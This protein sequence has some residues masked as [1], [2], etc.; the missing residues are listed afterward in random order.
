ETLGM[1][2]ERPD[3]VSGSNYR[4]E[5]IDEVMEVMRRY[6]LEMPLEDM[7]PTLRHHDDDPM[8]QAAAL[9][10]LG[11]LCALGPYNDFR[12]AL[13]SYQ[14]AVEDPIVAERVRPAYTNNVACVLAC[15]GLF[16][17]ARK[18]L[19]L[20]EDSP[21]VRHNLALMRAC[22][23]ERQLPNA[24]QLQFVSIPHA[25]VSESRRTCGLELTPGG[26][27]VWSDQHEQAPWDVFEGP[28]GVPVHPSE[29]EW[30][31]PAR[32]RR[33]LDGVGHVMLVMYGWEDSGG[34]T[35]LPRQVAYELVRRGYQVSVFYAAAEESEEFGPYAVHHERDRGV[36]LYGV[37]NRPSLFMDL[38]SPAREI[39][40]P[41][42]RGEFHRLVHELRPDVVHFFNLHNLG[43]SLPGVCKRAGIRTVFSSNNYWPVCPRLYLIDPRLE[44]CDGIGEHGSRCVTCTRGMGTPSEHSERA[45]AARTML[46]D[47]L[48]VHLAVSERVRE[49]YIENGAEPDNIRVL[50]QQPFGV[51]AIWRD[52]GSQRDIVASLDRPLRVGFIGSAMPHKGVHVLVQALQALPKGS[53][54]CVIHGDCDLEYARLLLKSDENDCIEFGGAYDSEHLAD[55]LRRVDVVVV[56]SVWEDCAPFV[57][58]EALAA[59]CPVVGSRMGGIPDFLEEDVTGML[60]QA[61]DA[62]ELAERLADF[63]RDPELLGRMQSAIAAPRGF[64]AYVSELEAVYAA[65]STTSAQRGAPLSVVP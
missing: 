28:N 42:V 14:E 60:F 49:I 24:Q 31:V 13:D 37:F 39:D 57:V 21:A 8:A 63:L 54:E 7:F 16:D 5:A 11:N 6:R 41:R 48:D 25:V 38:E 61:G 53:V 3:S 17:R 55:R 12:M 52:V 40:D 64:G 33:A 43:L 4:L 51:E 56:P 1:F 45:A 36:D 30:L 18:A 29:R 35:M 20:G 10:E 23:S 32:P 2:L 19:A 47:G 22:E 58:A 50:L 46:A 27:L 9:F 44:R 34:G 62:Q 59:R 15:Y 65:S 26:D